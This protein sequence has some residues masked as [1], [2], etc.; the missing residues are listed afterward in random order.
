M[1][2]PRSLALQAAL[3]LPIVAAQLAFFPQSRDAFL[4]A[5][6]LRSRAAR[7]RCS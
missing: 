6:I 3:F 2:A 1:E 5:K 4:D 7:R